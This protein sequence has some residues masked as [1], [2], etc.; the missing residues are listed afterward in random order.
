MVEGKLGRHDGWITL[1]AMADMYCKL[2]Y[3][4]CLLDISFSGNIIQRLNAEFLIIA[5]I[6]FLFLFLIM[7]RFST[8]LSC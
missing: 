5:M 6:F 3:G 7:V 4:G 8:I 2:A 1:R